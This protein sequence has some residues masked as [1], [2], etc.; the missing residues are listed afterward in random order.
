[1]SSVMLFGGRRSCTASIQRPGRSARAAKFSGWANI[2]V[3]K[4]PMA[5]AEAAP[6]LTVRPPTS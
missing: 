4:R 3:S 1:M 2:P 6:C 5:L